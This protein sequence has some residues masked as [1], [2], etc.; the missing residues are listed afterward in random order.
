MVGRTGKEPSCT[1]LELLKMQ[2]TFARF[3]LKSLAAKEQNVAEMGIA[4]YTRC[5]LLACLQAF[6]LSHGLLETQLSYL[7]V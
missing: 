3:V 4:S 6:L 7:C 5:V 1:V 2:A